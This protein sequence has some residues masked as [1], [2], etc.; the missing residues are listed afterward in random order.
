MDDVD[1]ARPEFEKARDVFYGLR[2]A[3]LR[4]E[5]LIAPAAAISRAIGNREALTESE[6]DEALKTVLAG[7]NL[8]VGPGDITDLITKLQNLG[9]IWSPGGNLENRYFAGISSLL[10]YVARMTS[11]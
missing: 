8:P 5:D 4:E 6:V 7:E 9:Y 11:T 3:G 2:Y 1:R 10:T